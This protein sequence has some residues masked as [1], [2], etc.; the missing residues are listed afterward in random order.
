MPVTAGIKHTFAAAGFI[1][2]K[3][4]CYPL[5]CSTVTPL[6]NRNKLQQSSVTK[7]NLE[8]PFATLVSSCSDGAYGLQGFRASRVFMVSGVGFRF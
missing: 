3:R 7:K 1:G 2:L 8:S 5:V 6:L 4:L